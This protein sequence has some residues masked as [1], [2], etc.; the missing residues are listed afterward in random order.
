VVWV[1]PEQPSLGTLVEYWRAGGS[2]DDVFRKTVFFPHP[3]KTAV[4]GP[5]TQAVL[6]DDPVNPGSP[7]WEED[8][9]FRARTIGRAP[10]G[11]EEDA[12]SGWAGPRCDV[13]TAPG[14][15]L[16]QYLGWPQIP[17]PPEGPALQALYLPG[18]GLTA[19][20]LAAAPSGCVSFHD[21][22]DISQNACFPNLGQE[23]SLQVECP[24]YCDELEAAFQGEGGFVAYRQE[25]DGAGVAGEFYQVSAHVP[26]VHCVDDG[27]SQQLAD[28]VIHWISMFNEAPPWNQQSLM[29]LD[30]Y[31]NAV[32]T[33]YRYQFVYF[34]A[35]GEIT[36]YRTSNWVTAVAG[37]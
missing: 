15:E 23:V 7:D 16:P 29:F 28:P 14:F 30:R 20:W 36:G 31:P 37:P 1:P 26:G 27:L 18:D 8:W 19:V 9:C 13:R 2:D 4:D 11:E 32:G 3:E 33:Q 6:L 5:L 24:G 35:R 12:L 25:R 10:P 21:C 22:F 34:D 17:A